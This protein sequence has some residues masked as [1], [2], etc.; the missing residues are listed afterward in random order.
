MT[1]GTQVTLT[2]PDSAPPGTIL[3][4]PVRGGAEKV[5]VRVPEG[6]GAG[7]TVI[8]QQQDN[9][10][11][12]DVRVGTVVPPAQ[13]QDSS[14]AAGAVSAEEGYLREQAALEQAWLSQQQ[15][16]TRQQQEISSWT[17]AD[18]TAD[19]ARQREQQALEQ[20]WL[21]QQQQQQQPA[22]QQ[23]LRQA[24]LNIQQTAANQ[25]A[26]A[27]G[28]QRAAEEEERKL[29]AAE[30][31]QL[32]LRQEDQEIAS[33]AAA[34][35]YVTWNG[36][37][38]PI[39]PEASLRTL[40]ANEL[41]EHAEFL[42]RAFGH[43][44]LGVAP[45][46]EYEQ[47]LSWV[48]QVQT[49]HLE[50]LRGVSP[51]PEMEGAVAYTVRL[52][53]T[54][55]IINIIV[56][57]DW[58]PAG[59][60]RFLE[61]AAA[62]DLNDLAFYRSI[63]GCIVQFG[64]PA[65]RQWP[66]IPDD[67]ATGVPF[68]LGAVSFA[69]IGENSRKS[70]LFICI[71]DMSHCLGQNSWETPI[72]AVA[73]SSLDV[74]DRIETCYGDIAEFNGQGPDTSCINAQGNNYL[75]KNFPK[76]SYITQAQTLDWVPDAPQE[77]ADSPP[78]TQ[79]ETP[80]G[81][82]QNGKAEAAARAAQEAQAQ[83]QLAEQLAQ[84]AASASQAS[85]ASQAAKAAQAAAEA[86]QAA[87]IAAQE[88]RAD[89]AAA[90]AAEAMRAEAS[91][92]SRRKAD[93]AA[94][95]PASVAGSSPTSLGVAAPRPAGP[96]RPRS[97]V[98]RSVVGQ[99]AMPRSGS[100]LGRA[101]TPSRHQGQNVVDVQVEVVPRQRP[102]APATVQ[103]GGAPATVG[104][105]N[106]GLIEVPRAQQLSRH[107]SLVPPPVQAAHPGSGAS[108]VVMSAVAASS[109][110]QPGRPSMVPTPS[111]PRGLQAPPALLAPGSLFPQQ[112]GQPMFDLTQGQP[113]LQPRA[114]QARPMSAGGV[115]QA[116]QLLD[117][118]AGMMAAAQA[119]Q[120]PGPLVPPQL[121][122]GQQFRR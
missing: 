68:L 13:P 45:P 91:T 33:A 87:M 80:R 31:K 119:P 12:W 69:A 86:A 60:R 53:T 22:Q 111:M 114:Q 62:G 89:V 117:F 96:A 108:S 102:S 101:Q 121:L 90:A 110:S 78:K 28:A 26:A 37:Q 49:L 83:A 95:T 59:T 98:R 116:P 74:L 29:R 88:A 23:D 65:K 54:V 52:D 6:L 57:P 122:Q 66:P 85:F 94:V 47:V 30:E 103:R 8:L 17:A 16:Q 109:Q 34:I 40:H 71:G 36:L 55:G 79:Q 41:N 107:P 118:R 58:A 19:E 75:K 67:P 64:L 39:V 24:E 7:S 63:K 48:V 27:V 97:P 5:K 120:A 72:G 104:P 99:Q 18:P 105:V 106:N 11:E 50:T 61:L 70:T 1:Q 100:A 38:L 76:L 77:V 14:S 9:S 46:Q 10:D 42:Y 15:Q 32:L 93:P 25:L 115:A 21:Q 44:R 112:P 92:P 43:D 56:R 51:G 35:E 4:V 3:S 113:S 2:I 82:G 81:Q 84:Q 73:E 20:A